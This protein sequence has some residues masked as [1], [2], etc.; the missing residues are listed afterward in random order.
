MKPRSGP[1]FLTSGMMAYTAPSPDCTKNEQ[2]M[3]TAIAA[4]HV[5]HV[6]G[7]DMNVHRLRQVEALRDGPGL[8]ATSAERA[9]FARTEFPTRG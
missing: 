6:Y 3:Q 8:P 4:T 9:A 2:L 5:H 1:V 7:N